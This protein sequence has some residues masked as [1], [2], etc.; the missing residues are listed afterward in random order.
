MGSSSQKDGE[1]GCA[2][3]SRQPGPGP[4]RCAETCPRS[5]GWAL[6][7]WACKQGTILRPGST[8]LIKKRKQQDSAS[9]GS[10]SFPPESWRWDTTCLQGLCEAFRRWS[11][12]RFRA[13]PL[14][15][16]AHRSSWLT[17][18]VACRMVGSASQPHPEIHWCPPLWREE[19]G[20]ATWA[21]PVGAAGSRWAKSGHREPHPPSGALLSTS[22]QRAL[23][24]VSEEESGCPRTDPNSEPGLGVGSSLGHTVVPR[25]WWQSRAGMAELTLQPRCC[26]TC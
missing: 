16:K 2:A 17:W 15:Y 12:G 24:Q 6:N 11:L 7:F 4:G 14:P 25:T 13:T 23:V 1:K 10:L 3:G 9:S 18:E 21:P 20:P 5:P 8:C 26:P 22:V 19:G